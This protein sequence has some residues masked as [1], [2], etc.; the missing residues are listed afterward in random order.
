[1]AP[2]YLLCIIQ[3]VVHVPEVPLYQ[4]SGFVLLPTMPK[5]APAYLKMGGQS[6]SKSC[7]KELRKP[8]KNRKDAG[9]MNVCQ[10]FVQ[11]ITVDWCS[12]VCY[13]D[14]PPVRYDA[15]PTTPTTSWYDCLF[16]SCFGSASVCFAL[17][18]SFIMSVFI[19][20]KPNKVGALN[21]SHLYRKKGSSFQTQHQPAPPTD[22]S[23]VAAVASVAARPPVDP[24]TGSLDSRT[25]L[26]S[27]PWAPWRKSTLSSEKPPTT[28]LVDTADKENKHESELED[29]EEED[30]YGPPKRNNSS[31]EEAD[32]PSPK[33]P[34]NRDDSA[35]RSSA[36][37]SKK[38]S[39]GK[40][41]RC[42]NNSSDDEEPIRDP[43][44]QQLHHQKEKC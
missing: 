4:P 44:L 8:G 41:T 13:N 27:A 10:C 42:N 21:R 17:F 28:L 22:P 31:D 18:V 15:L 25:T 6:G 20:M 3:C 14:T 24:E 2:R 5:C 1:M 26:G 38:S 36:S 9:K 23:A 11:C 40:K 32:K 43:A 30:I 7:G 33:K 37:S 34:R 35:R 39:T 16:L 19:T 12:L 29:E